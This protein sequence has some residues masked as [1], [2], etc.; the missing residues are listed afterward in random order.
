MPFRAEAGEVSSSR[1]QRSIRCLGSAVSATALQ[2][3][4]A[5]RYSDMAQEEDSKAEKSGSWSLRSAIQSARESAEE[6]SSS[7]PAKDTSTLSELANDFDTRVSSS[8]HGA[9]LRDSCDHAQRRLDFRSTD[10]SVYADMA[11]E[12]LHTRLLRVYGQMDTNT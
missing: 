7:L 2:V 9:L 11:V 8:I 10:G 5:C 4:A 12:Q 1:R 3:T 6:V